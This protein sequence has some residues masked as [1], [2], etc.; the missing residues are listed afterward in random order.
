MVAAAVIV[1]GATIGIYVATHSGHHD[2]TICYSTA[3]PAEDATSVPVTCSSQSATSIATGN[4]TPSTTSVHPAASVAV[5][6]SQTLTSDGYRANAGALS[7][8]GVDQLP[9]VTLTDVDSTTNIVNVN[10]YFY[11]KKGKYLGTFYGSDTG[12][13]P[14][15]STL[16]PLSNAD[17]APTMAQLEAANWLMTVSTRSS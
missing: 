5:P 1:A 7:F 2:V 12:L 15:Q 13:M 9:A 14:G 3:G 11:T 6:Q 16:L 8:Y 17:L 4:A 10:F